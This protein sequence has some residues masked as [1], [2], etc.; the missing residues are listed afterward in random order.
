MQ[1][2]A[3]GVPGEEV[4]CDPRPALAR[5]TVPVLAITG[6]Q[7]VQVPP[8]DVAKIGRLAQGPFEGHVTGNLSHLFRPDPVSAGPRAYRRAVREPVDAEVPCSPDAG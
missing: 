8:Q 6:G 3:T 5:I 7:D 1:E 2:G 4:T